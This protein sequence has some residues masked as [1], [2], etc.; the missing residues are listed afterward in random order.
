LPRAITP[1]LH[2][3]GSGNLEAL[4]ISEDAGGLLL[5]QNALLAPGAEVARRPR[6]DVLAAL[7]V[8]EFRQAQD[9]AHQVEGA[10]LVVGLLHGR[11]DLV[12][13]LGDHVFQPD[14]RG[15]VAPGAKW[16]DAGHAEGLALR[17]SV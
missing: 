1:L 12:V 15:I 8:K 3:F 7:G 11:R 10:A 4:R 5:G 16:I 14:G 13:G 2:Y 17:S 9:D 6:I